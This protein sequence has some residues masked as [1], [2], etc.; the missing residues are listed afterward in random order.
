[1]RFIL[2]NMNYHTIGIIFYYPILVYII[3]V[4]TSTF[5]S[6]DEILDLIINLNRKPLTFHTFM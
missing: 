4:S 3:I 2:K 6:T 5:Y 1:M